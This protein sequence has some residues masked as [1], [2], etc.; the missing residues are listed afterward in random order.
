[1]KKFSAITL[2]WFMIL[3]IYNKHKWQTKEE[4]CGLSEQQGETDFSS[5]LYQ[6]IK[7][8]TIWEWYAVSDMNNSSHQQVL[9]GS[10]YKYYYYYY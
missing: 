6:A 7:Q 8:L 2:S 3:N 5:F 4:F 10:L 1:M 9:Y